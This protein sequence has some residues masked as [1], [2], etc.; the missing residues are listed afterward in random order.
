MLL[1]LYSSDIANFVS[2]KML[3]DLVIR[4]DYVELKMLFVFTNQ[5]N[6]VQVTYED[7]QKINLFAR[8]NA[9]LQDAKEELDNKKVCKFVY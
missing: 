4:K 7:Q 9:R 5:D 6:D 2:Y 8:T 3:V 1:D